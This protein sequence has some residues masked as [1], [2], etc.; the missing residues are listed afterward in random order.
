MNRKC[1]NKYCVGYYTNHYISI[2]E[3]RICDVCLQAPEIEPSNHND[4][5]ENVQPRAPQEL[6]RKPGIGEW[7]ELYWVLDQQGRLSDIYKEIN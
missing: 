1:S 6:V 3:T 4:L 2:N 5:G 7:C